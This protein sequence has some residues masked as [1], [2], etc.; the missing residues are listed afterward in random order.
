MGFGA[1]GNIGRTYRHVQRYRQI[2][3][4][5]FKYGLEELVEGLK[6]EQF[7]EMGL[8]MVYRRRR[9]RLDQM[10]KYERLRMALEELGPTFI[11]MGQILSTRPDLIPIPYAE[12]LAKLQS[13]VPA[14][15]F[16]DVS[17]M[18]ESQLRRPLSEVFEYFNPVP[19][20][21]ASIGQVH[22]ARL[23][24]GNEVVVKIQ[25]PGIRDKIEVDLEILHDLAQLMERYLEGWD[26][27]RPT[28]I[29][30]D[31]AASLERE[32]DFTIEAAHQERFAQQFADDK[33]IYVPKVY[34]EATTSHVLTMEFVEGIRPSNLARLRAEG[35]NLPEIAHRGAVLIMKQIFVH[36]FFHADPHPGNIF[37]F[38]QHVLC[39]LDFG[40]A[41]R[42]DR[43]SRETF[44]DLIMT[45]V[46]RDETRAADALLR[47]TR[48]EVEPDRCRMERDI[49]E[50]LDQHFYRPLKEVEFGRMLQQLAE[51]IWK[52]E[53]ELPPD[54]FLM[55]KALGTWESLARALDPDFDIAEQAKPFLRKILAGR[56]KPARMAKQFRSVGWQLYYILQ[57]LPNDIRDILRQARRGRLHIEFEH[58]GLEPVTMTLDRT[59]NRLAFSIVLAALII[60]S[61]LIVLAGVPPKWNEIPI[62]GLAGFVMSGL[63]GFRLLIAILRRGNM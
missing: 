38:P 54:L 17:P 18:V 52:Y 20:A 43:R 42:I 1:I 16:E 34:R 24:G 35:Y 21:A 63:M 59:S 39:Y 49:A 28:T 44:A 51:L 11:K 9:E 31:L 5:V 48:W 14:V 27:R 10:T 58:R 3:S 33:T 2:I 15:P 56:W 23:P 40:M 6:I 29:V 61:S 46:A 30:G 45:L 7:V 57:D 62:I 55:F 8:R 41:G 32:L 60:G 36:G 47:L 13:Q 4:I 37:V 53:L 26:A 22:R 19:L 12:E 50:F 25:R